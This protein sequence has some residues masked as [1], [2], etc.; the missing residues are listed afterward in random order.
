M[1]TVERK[2]SINLLDKSNIH[3]H[4]KAI[5]QQVLELKIVCV[6]AKVFQG[7]EYILTEI[8]CLERV[9][10]FTA[11]EKR[12]Q[13]HKTKKIKSLGRTLLQKVGLRLKISKRQEPTATVGSTYRRHSRSCRIFEATRAPAGSK[14]SPTAHSMVQTRVQLGSKFCVKQR[15]NEHRSSL[16]QL[17]KNCGYV[18]DYAWDKKEK[19][20]IP[21]RVEDQLR[22]WNAFGFRKMKKTTQTSLGESSSQLVD[23]DDEDKDSSGCPWHQVYRDSKSSRRY[24]DELAY[25]RASV[26]C[27]E[28]MLARLCSKFLPD[29]GTNGGGSTDMDCFPMCL[30]ALSLWDSFPLA[31]PKQQKKLAEKKG[32]EIAE[33]K[34]DVLVAEGERSHSRQLQRKKAEAAKSATVA[35]LSLSSWFDTLI[36]PYYIDLVHL[37]VLGLKLCYKNSDQVSGAVAKERKGKKR[38]RIKREERAVAG[39]GAMQQ[40]CKQL[41]KPKGRAA[42][43]ENKQSQQKAAEETIE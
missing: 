41:R 25:H 33:K 34:T 17:L 31:E 22:D 39:R 19:K 7:V 16:F 21:L 1:V 10:D 38:K 28:V 42:C 9:K 8:L 2:C 24:V 29:Q 4:K 20:L 40:Q 32:D 6:V 43:E 3:F 5:N 14:S 18:W 11:N 37:Q 26:D 36:L 30:P 13:N 27:Q 23:D 35:K 12:L 15:S